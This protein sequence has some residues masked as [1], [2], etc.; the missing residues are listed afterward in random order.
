MCQILSRALRVHD[1]KDMFSQYSQPL[2]T[3]YTLFDKLRR[4]AATVRYMSCLRYDREHE[5]A[6]GWTRDQR[7]VCGAVKRR[8]GVSLWHGSFRVS[9]RCASRCV[10]KCTMAV[11]DADCGCGLSISSLSEP[12]F[13][14]TPVTT[15]YTTNITPQADKMV[16]R[17]AD[18]A[19]YDHVRD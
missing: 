18:S 6:V 12:P 17:H 19:R 10:L 1:L 15:L 7:R 13:T 14:G 8:D 5:D 4:Y 9:Y 3:H 11:S 2:L 16:A